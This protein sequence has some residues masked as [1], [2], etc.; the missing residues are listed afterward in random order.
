MGTTASTAASTTPTAM[1]VKREQRKPKHFFDVSRL[2]LLKANLHLKIKLANQKTG[3][4]S[5]SVTQR[6][7]KELTLELDQLAKMRKRLQ[8]ELRY[9]QEASLEP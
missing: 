6:K 3:Q 5:R 7:I 9:W 1:N 2:D 8:K 4:K